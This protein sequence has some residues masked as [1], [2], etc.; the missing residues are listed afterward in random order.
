MRMSEV[1]AERMGAELEQHFE[2]GF[3]LDDVKHITT[4]VR[5]HGTIVA[6][7]DSLPW[8]GMMLAWPTPDEWAATQAQSTYR[9]TV[10][11][12]PGGWVRFR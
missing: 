6:L 4:P 9:R 5:I 10:F 7:D 1:T 2:V 3:T 11:F 12:D 8:E